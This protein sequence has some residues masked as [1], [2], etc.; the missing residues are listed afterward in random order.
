M[1]TP[2]VSI[3]VPVYN[4]EK[5]IRRCIDSILA[6]TFSDF[7]CILVDD[8]SPDSCPAICD[9]YAKIDARIKVVHKTKNEGIV[10]ARKTALEHSCG[11]YIQF[12]DSDDWLEDDMIE[13][14]YYKA[15]AGALIVYCDFLAT[16]KNGLGIV[17]KIFDVKGLDKTEIIKSIITLRLIHNLWNKLFARKLFNG[18]IFPDCKYLEDISMCYQL[19]LNAN[20]IKYEHAILYHYEYNP[21]G[22][23]NTKIKTGE[24]AVEKYIA[25]KQLESILSARADYVL[26]KNLFKKV[27]H[28]HKIDYIIAK[29]KLMPLKIF[30]IK[31][32][33]AVIPYGL[34]LLYKKRKSI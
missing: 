21:T 5:Y 20:K 19:F 24:I 12:I 4:T 2:K 25:Y 11:E 9:H 32:I 15:N 22:I 13:R 30:L 26:Y 1:N 31:A 28:A 18:M 14:L 34:F 16:D 3:L 29:L 23:C 27:L 17:P 33:R 10:L 8:A 7:E 6:Q